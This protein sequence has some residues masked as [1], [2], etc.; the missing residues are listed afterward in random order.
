MKNIFYLLIILFFA[1][2]KFDGKAQENKVTMIDEK[3]NDYYGEKYMTFFDAWSINRNDTKLIDSTLYYLDKII[4][5]DPEDSG[6]IQEKANFLIYN[7]L[8]ERAL[9][10]IDSISNVEPFFKMMSGT[11]SL[12]LNKENSEKLLKEAHRKSIQFVKEYND[13]NDIFWKII[14]D[15]YFQGKEYALT[16]I[17]KAKQNI[18][19]D[20]VISTFEELEKMINEKSKKE[21]LYDIFNIE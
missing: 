14:L 7:K 19:D 15:N 8:Y 9:K 21:I 2:C 5:C 16:E 17:K 1:S 20:Y 12:K 10:E 3:C 13:P 6:S 11:L 4:S 18:T